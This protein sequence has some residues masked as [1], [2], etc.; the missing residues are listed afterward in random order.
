MAHLLDPRG[1]LNLAYDVVAGVLGLHKIRQVVRHLL[2]LLLRPL[3]HLKR[4]IDINIIRMHSPRHL[5]FLLIVEVVELRI[6]LQSSLPD[7]EVPWPA[8]RRLTM[9]ALKPLRENAIARIFHRYYMRLQ[10]HPQV[11]S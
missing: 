6:Y 4:I 10:I 8:L 5:H 11:F 3:H 2:A 1:L 7:G 9:P